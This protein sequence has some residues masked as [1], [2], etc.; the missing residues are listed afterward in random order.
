[1]GDGEMLVSVGEILRD[2]F[3]EGVERAA[4]EDVIGRIQHDLYLE[5]DV[6]VIEGEP[7]VAEAAVC[8]GDGRVGGFHLQRS[9]YL[10]IVTKFLPYYTVH[11][12]Y[13]AAGVQ[14]AFYREFSLYERE[15]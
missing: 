2:A 12:H 6:D 9:F 3:R 7:Y 10:Q 1:M 15:D 13:L 14:D 5:V 8:L 4:E 11:S